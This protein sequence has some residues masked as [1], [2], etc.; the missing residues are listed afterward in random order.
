MIRCPTSQ[1]DQIMNLPMDTDVNRYE[2]PVRTPF[3][4][5]GMTKT[6]PQELITAGIDDCGRG[7]S[8]TV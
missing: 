2:K 1:D 4:I 5:T 8:R 3:G 6:R 7:G